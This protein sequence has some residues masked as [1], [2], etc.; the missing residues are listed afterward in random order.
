MIFKRIATAEYYFFQVAGTPLQPGNYCCGSRRRKSRSLTNVNFGFK[1]VV[2]D[3]SGHLCSN[4]SFMTMDNI[5][6]TC[7]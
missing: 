5:S 4:K 7:H 1:Q 3:S 6:I 2:C